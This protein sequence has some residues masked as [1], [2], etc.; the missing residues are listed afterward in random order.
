LTNQ[1]F[2]LARLDVGRVGV[3]CSFNTPRLEEK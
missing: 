2:A 3:F 1:C